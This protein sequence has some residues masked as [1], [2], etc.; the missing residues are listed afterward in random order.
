[1]I[2]LKPSARGLS[3]ATFSSS[4]G[5]GERIPWRDSARA[6]IAGS[7]ENGSVKKILS[8]TVPLYWKSRIRL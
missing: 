1:M 2:I 7:E 3:I 6:I 8:K 5:F 4:S